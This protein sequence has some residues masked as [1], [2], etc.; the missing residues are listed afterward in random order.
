[1]VT[2]YKADNPGSEIRSKH[3]TKV[4]VDGVRI[5]ADAIAREAQQHPGGTPVEAWTSAARALVVRE[6]L[7]GEARRRGIVARAIE[8]GEG[9]RET[10]E[11][12]LVRALV[13]QDVETPEPDEAS[14]RRYYDANTARF[15]PSEIV[16]A[17]HIL[18]AARP[19]DAEPLAAARLQARDLLE[20]LARRPASFAD[21]A[22]STS[23]CPSAQAGGNLGQLTR[24]D[25]T[26]A[27]EA[28]LL[29]LE[30]G[31]MSKSPVETPYGLHI[32]RLDRRIDGKVL[33]FEAVRDRIAGYLTERSRRL[34]IAQY[35][36]RISRVARIEGIELPDTSDLRVS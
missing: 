16:E 24:G 25:T 31:E 17:R 20:V 5:P 19:G 32:I 28:A 14:C 3:Q 10:E 33:P 4:S 7:L 6:L 36:A 29:A 2:L 1:M 22:R 13:D 23:A 8:D 30:E 35:L 21:L 12:A 9:R 34:A 15:R 18:L 27:F 26:P 11:E